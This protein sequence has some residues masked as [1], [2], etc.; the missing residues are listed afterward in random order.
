MGMRYLQPYYSHTYLTAWHCRF[1]S[2]SHTP[3]KTLQIGIFIL[4]QIENIIYLAAWYHK[5]V[6]S[7]DRINVKKGKKTV[8]LSHLVAGY[9][10]SCYT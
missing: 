2:L 8:I 9:L 10:A 6:T 4:T 3:C 1:Y 7:L 5:R